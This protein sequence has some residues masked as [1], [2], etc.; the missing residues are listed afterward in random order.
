MLSPTTTIKTKKQK[1]KKD[2]NLPPT[3]GTPISEQTQ[4]ELSLDHNAP[5]SPPEHVVKRALA[6][7][8]VKPL[9]E[10]QKALDERAN[11][12]IKETAKAIAKGAAAVNKQ[13]GI[14]L[15]AEVEIIHLG[16]IAKAAKIL[17]EELKLDPEKAFELAKK[18]ITG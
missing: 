12:G 9:P 13:R 1:N 15:L 8:G 2:D 7:L 14:E 6:K 16:Y 17:I 3:S 10:M 18:Q 5:E 4:L 11:N